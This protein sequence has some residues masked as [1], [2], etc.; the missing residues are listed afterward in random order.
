MHL[1]DKG[2][3]VA[4]KKQLPAHIINDSCCN[5]RF[6]RRLDDS[7]QIPEGDVI[8]ECRRYP[9]TVFGIEINDATIQALPETEA[10]FFCGEHGRPIQ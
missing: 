9:P 6:W 8:G 4:R 10:Q 5:C 7:E 1:T 3:G 2:I